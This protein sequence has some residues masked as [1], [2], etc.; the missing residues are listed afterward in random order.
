VLVAA[1]I[2]DLVPLGVGLGLG[3]PSAA[4]WRR[5][6]SWIGWRVLLTRNGRRWCGSPPHEAGFVGPPGIAA[7]A[8]RCFGAACASMVR[9]QCTRGPLQ[10]PVSRPWADVQALAR[11]R[12]PSNDR[13]RG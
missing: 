8:A 12:R 11:Q 2:G 9:V 7:T 4:F 6:I 5:S 1:C 13:A 3:L 10:N